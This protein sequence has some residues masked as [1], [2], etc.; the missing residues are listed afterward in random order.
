[1]AEGLFVP[2][3]LSPILPESPFAFQE[4]LLSFPYQSNPE[5]AV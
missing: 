2:P 4:V 5:A 3:G 1:M